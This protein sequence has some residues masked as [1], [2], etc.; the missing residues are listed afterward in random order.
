M[1]RR[2]VGNVVAALVVAGLLGCAM[3]GEAAG[4]GSANAF[5]FWA[6]TL[7]SG[8]IL[9]EILET[10]DVLQKQL[11]ATRQTMQELAEA[12]MHAMLEK[13][14]SGEINLEDD[15]VVVQES[16]GNGTEESARRELGE[17]GWQPSPNPIKAYLEAP[18]PLYGGD[19]V[20]AAETLWSSKDDYRRC[21]FFGG[22]EI[23]I[24]ARRYFIRKSVGFACDL[25]LKKSVISP[26]DFFSCGRPGV[27]TA[28]CLEWPIEIKAGSFVIPLT[29]PICLPDSRAVEASLKILG[30]DLL[31][32]VNL[33]V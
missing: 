13:I 31:A 22:Q 7:G 15:Y 23:C 12:Q 1:A 18:Q 17:F 10:K 16:E 25:Q 21:T 2:G 32:A 9:E 29:V 8:N 20:E 33:F 3:A 5:G 30:G 19:L 4:Q 11:S 28:L 24:P 27:S 6:N 26:V 14:Q